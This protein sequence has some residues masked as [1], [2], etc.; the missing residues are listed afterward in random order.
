VLDDL[1]TLGGDAFVKELASQFIGDAA[2]LMGALEQAVRHAD[3]QS[4]RDHAHALRSA[5]ANIGASGIHQMCL[6]WR[7]IGASELAARG[8]AHLGK[9]AAELERVGTVLDSHLAGPDSIEKPAQLHP[10]GRTGAAH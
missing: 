9:L 2:L 3:V 6:S 1:R 10:A 7:G 8:A 5:A 4:F